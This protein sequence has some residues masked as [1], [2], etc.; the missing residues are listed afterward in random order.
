MTQPT[1]HPHQRQAQQQRA[2]QNRLSA[3]LV[4]LTEHA[5]HENERP[6]S[7]S[8]IFFVIF[9]YFSTPRHSISISSRTILYSFLPAIS[10]Q[11]YVC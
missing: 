2:P 5:R 9:R 7:R 6:F 10:F 8:A 11:C 1:I 3:A 4:E